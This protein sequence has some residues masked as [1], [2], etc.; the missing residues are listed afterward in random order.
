[1]RRTFAVLSLA[2]LAAAC[3]GGDGDGARDLTTDA[4]DAS[5]GVTVTGP[6]GEKP[7]VAL[8]DGAPPAGLVTDDL[9][10]GDGPEAHDGDSID[11]HY[12]GVSWARQEAFD[13][14]F[15]RTS[16]TLTLGAGQVIRGWEQ[17]LVGMKVGGRRL[18]IIPP[19][20]GYGDRGA[21]E[22]I[23]PG[24][25]LVFVVDLLSVEDGA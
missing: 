12:Y 8:P 17:G 21:G 13:S 7:T 11:V 4:P 9:V 5:H 23:P 14:S 20:L 22:S 6:L 1:M 3:G 16:F 2:L 25:T 10:E 18:L 15:G 24:D 19:E